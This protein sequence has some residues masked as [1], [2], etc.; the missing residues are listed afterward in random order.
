MALHPRTRALHIGRAQQ[1]CILHDFFTSLPAELL[2]QILGFLPNFTM[3]LSAVLT[4]SSSAFKYFE[5]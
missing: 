3:V 4:H 2:A 1:G 5:R